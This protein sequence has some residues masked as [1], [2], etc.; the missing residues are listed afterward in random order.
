MTRWKIEGR[1]TLCF[2]FVQFVRYFVNWRG[3][4]AAYRRAAAIAALEFRDGLK[5]FH[6]KA[7]DAIPLFWVDA[8]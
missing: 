7:H 1:F 2:L 4:R 8:R 3:V 5:M 6:G